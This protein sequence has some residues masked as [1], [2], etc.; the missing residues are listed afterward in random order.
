MLFFFSFLF[1][2]FALGC[3]K[4]LSNFPPRSAIVIFIWKVDLIYNWAS[5]EFFFPA[6]LIVRAFV[7][8][9]CSFLNIVHLFLPFQAFSYAHTLSQI[10]F[11]CT[12]PWLLVHCCAELFPLSSSEDVS[13]GCY[14]FFSMPPGLIYYRVY[15]FS[16]C[17][18]FGQGREM[19]ILW[20]NRGA[21]AFTLT[22]LSHG[23][24][25]ES[26]LFLQAWAALDSGFCTF[27]Q[28]PSRFM[29]C[30][31]F[32]SVFLLLKLFL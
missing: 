8:S 2:F 14:W 6:I 26:F 18:N 30:F 10:R 20:G 5:S 23:E 29:F 27:W 7:C 3:W 9:L 19:Q 24:A 17:V 25:D 21:S 12:L 4:N 11:N 16:P 13:S 28:E 15:F 22:L 1:F 32:G 31:N